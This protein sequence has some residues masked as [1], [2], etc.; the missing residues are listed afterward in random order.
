MDNKTRGAWVVHHAD[1]LRQVKDPGTF[2]NILVAG[3]AATVLASIAA[4]DDAVLSLDR[5]RS[6]AKANGVNQLELDSVLHRLESQQLLERDGT[7]IQVLAVTTASVLQHTARLL[8]DLSPTP[9]EEASLLLAEIASQRP[10]GREALVEQLGDE[11]QL[12][13]ADVADLLFEAEQIGFVDAE[14][15]AADKLYF[16]GNLFRRDDVAKTQRVL[17]SLGADERQ[18]LTTL[19][20][21][22]RARGC[23][24]LPAA[25][26]VL[27]SSLMQKSTAVG[28]LDV[29]GVD[30]EKGTTLFV[31][32]PGAFAKFGD[33][34]HDDALDMAKALVAC[35]TYGMTE[36]SAQEGRIRLPGALIRKLVTGQEIGGAAPAIGKDYLALEYKGVVRV[37]RDG[38]NY[39]MKLLKRDVGELALAVLTSGDASY[40][41]VSLQTAQISKY[42]PPE[43]RRVESRKHVEGLKDNQRT[44]RS[45]ENMLQALRAL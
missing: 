16:N 21:E 43:Y 44:K 27:G 36:R 25:E 24:S 19:D 37:R 26:K 31:T 13:G 14:G 1:K 22:L 17:D 33:P 3:K 29:H 30:N 39:Y 23:I 2:E 40:E 9:A 11:H 10:V 15:Q 42:V 20:E 6:L 7:E 38:G 5:V 32:R 34:F 45:V 4:T 41:A 28:L 12:A 35:F 8:N 18:R